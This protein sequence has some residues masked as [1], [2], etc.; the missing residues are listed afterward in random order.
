MIVKILFKLKLSCFD[1]IDEQTSL[2]RKYNTLLMVKRIQRNQR[3]YRKAKVRNKE[4][5]KLK[6][7]TWIML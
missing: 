1:I 2:L 5:N 7:F 4:I 3:Q 6:M